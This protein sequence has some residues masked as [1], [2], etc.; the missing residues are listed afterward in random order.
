MRKVGGYDRSS[1][2]SS[3]KDVFELLIFAF[4]GGGVELESY[5]RGSL[6]NCIDS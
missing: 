1:F 6:A 5:R 2:F 4:G 3:A